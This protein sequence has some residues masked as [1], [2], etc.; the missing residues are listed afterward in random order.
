MTDRSAIDDA[1]R[2]DAIVVGAGPAGCAA[3]YRLAQAGLSVVLIERGETP[4]SKNLSGG[5][6]YSAVLNELLPNFY[7]DAPVERPITRHA[8]TFITK[9][10][11]CSLDYRSTTLGT[12]PYNAFSVLRAKF[13]AWFGD[14][15]ERAGAFV[16][17][18]IRV[19]DLIIE[20]GA[21]VGVRAGDETLRAGV[22]VAADGVNSFLA[23]AAGLRPRNAP[24]DVAVGVKGIIKLPRETIEDRFGL[25]GDEGAAYSFVGDVTGGLAGGGFL[26]TNIDSLSVGV[27][28]R[29]DELV[30]SGVKSS[31]FLQDF[32]AHP[33]LQPLVRRG[34]LAEYGSHLVPEG[35]AEMT[36][37]LFTGGM[38]VVGDAAGFA[39]NNGLV[40]RGMDLA[41]GSGVCAA[42]TIIEANRLGDFS[43]RA[44]GAYQDRLRDSFVLKDL[45]TY[46]RAPHLLDRRRLYTTYPQF[47]TQLLHDIFVTDGT[48]R[49]HLLT[50]VRRA[51]KESDL[52]TSE[53]ARDA[54]AAVRAL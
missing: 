41:I 4:G 13:D 26:Y 24:H 25:S 31:Q 17:P 5:V 15:A 6:L 21:V 43:A 51:M 16:M 14:V 2:F 36:G 48:P 39:L 52:T 47:L 22:V 37:R 46:A 50:T 32:L 38:L 30:A 28:V 12:A 1:E 45:H 27:V 8:T 35:G 40:V 7:T 34:E 19:D 18:G 44:L 49:D 42:D 23:Q 29:L 54:L 53:V 3:A 20:D 9:D 10:S 11:S 33:L